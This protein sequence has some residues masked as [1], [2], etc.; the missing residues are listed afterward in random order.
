[1]LHGKDGFTRQAAFNIFPESSN[2]AQHNIYNDE[3]KET[4]AGFGKTQTSAT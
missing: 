3:R 2:N 4:L 1:M